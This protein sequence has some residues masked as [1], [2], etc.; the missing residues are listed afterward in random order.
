MLRKHFWLL[1]LCLALTSAWLDP[2]LLAGAGFEG[3]EKP[4]V[5]VPSFR[6][7]VRPLFQTK[8]FRCHGEK[9]RKA[10]LDLRTPAGILQ[11]GESGPV[12]VPGNPQKSP[13]DEKL[14]SGKM[15]PG[16]KDRLSQA[17]VDTIRRWITAGAPFGSED[18]IKS[19]AAA[20]KVTQHDVLPILWRR[21]TVCH[22]L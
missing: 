7:E 1:L 5:Q 21:C 19:E 18:A 22:G 16:K 13:L 12:I 14:R 9:G 6:D 10:D 17:Q 15:P 8:C 4:P 20:G 2:T 3:Q 11:G